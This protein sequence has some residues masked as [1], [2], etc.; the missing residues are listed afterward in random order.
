M[1]REVLK[2][3]RWSFLRVAGNVEDAADPEAEGTGACR[4]PAQVL[5]LVGRVADALLA[6]L[7]GVASGVGKL[8][9]VEEAKD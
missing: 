1:R 4:S 3:R 8:D 6:L 7:G 2:C 9:H 5:A